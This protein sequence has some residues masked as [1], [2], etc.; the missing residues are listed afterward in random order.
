MREIQQ[1]I[2]VL[3][4]ILAQVIRLKS[5]ERY[6]EAVQ[7]IHNAYGRLDLSPRPV[8]ELTASELLEL[9]T[10]P[11]G[12]STDLALAIADLLREEGDI[13]EKMGEDE[14][15]RASNAKSLTLYGQARATKGAALPMDLGEKIRDLEER[16]DETNR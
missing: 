11:Q 13:L 15:A 6:E 3:L 16:L 8:G 7:A 12:F 1:A 4:Q 10:T 2:G 9:C 14:A 5:E